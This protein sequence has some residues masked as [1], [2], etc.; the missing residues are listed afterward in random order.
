MLPFPPFATHSLNL[1]S[2]LSFDAWAQP[3]PSFS[4]KDLKTDGFSLDS[5]RN[6]VNLMDVSSW[7]CG[8]G[9]ASLMLSLAARLLCRSLGLTLWPF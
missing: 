3:P 8:Q 5:C 9:P 2:R 1:L 6:M 4:D 7:H